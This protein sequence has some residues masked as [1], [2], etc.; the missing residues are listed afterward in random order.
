MDPEVA[1]LIAELGLEPLP[2]EGGWFRQTW[3]AEQIVDGRPG[4]TAI[5]ALWA[6]GADGFSAMH[7]LASTEVW[8]FYRG[9]PFALLLLHPDG[10]AEE[11]ALGP[12]GAVQVVVPAGVWMG[13]RV[14]DGGRYA[15]TGATMAPGFTPEDF[16]LGSAEQLC[17]AYPSVAGRIRRLT[18]E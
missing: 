5:V 4:G 9:D 17:A 12:G 3:Q 6:D 7:R 1:A 16:E 14:A 18:R 2:E 15:L 8:H 13:G 10:R 11:V